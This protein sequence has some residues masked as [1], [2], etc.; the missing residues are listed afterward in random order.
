MSFDYK[1]GENC[2]LYFVNLFALLSDCSG[3][4]FKDDRL[5]FGSILFPAEWW[6][7]ASHAVKSVSRVAVHQSQKRHF[8]RFQ[9]KYESISD[10]VRERVN[11]E[12]TSLDHAAE[13]L[14]AWH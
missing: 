8:W 6:S 4:A 12:I 7:Y 2:A 3:C 1:I 13:P 11:W 5:S 9:E 14:S 10:K